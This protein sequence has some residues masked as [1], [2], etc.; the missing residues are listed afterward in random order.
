[1]PADNLEVAIRIRTQLQEALADF[2][3]L[4]QSL[5]KSGL[6]ADQA[7]GRLRRL[8]ATLDSVVRGTTTLGRHVRY[9]GIAL[10]GLSAGGFVRGVVRNTV[11]Q[12]QAIAQ[13]EARIRATGAAAGLTST[14]IQGMAAALQDVTTYGDE[15]ILEMQALLLSFRALDGTQFE[16]ITETALDLA[17]AL[18]QAP[19]EAAIQLAK[20]LED[21]VQGLTA[22][23]RS[24]TIFS[25]AQTEVIRSLAETGR[26]A[27]AQRL[28]LDE[29]ARQYGGA[30]R[31]ARDTLGGALAALDNA[32][33][34]L[35]EHTDRAGEMTAAVES[36]VAALKDEEATRN[37]RDLSVALLGMLR[38]MVEHADTVLAVAGA[39]AGAGLGAR[40][41]LKGLLVG[42]V[43]GGFAG[44]SLL[45]DSDEE[46]VAELRAEL[47]AAA[48]QLGSIAA[49]R[50]AAGTNRIAI[51]NLLDEEAAAT[52]RFTAALTELQAA[53][54]D[55]GDGSPYAAGTAG[56]HPAD[57]RGAPPP[58]AL[59]PPAG[60]GEGSEA[61]RWEAELRRA[62]AR[63]E[64][65]AHFRRQRDAEE[66]RLDAAARE[67]AA[68]REALAGARG[69]L[70][71]AEAD[72]AGPYARALAEVARWEKGVR[73]A[74]ARAAAGE[75]DY[76]RL[77]VAAAARRAGAAEAEAQRRLE[78]ARDWQSGVRRALADL[79]REWSDWG[80]AAEDATRTAVRGAEDAIVGFVS[81]GRV[82]IGDFARYVT[83]TLAR[84][85]V[86][87][88]FGLPLASLAADLFAP[89][90]TGGANGLPGYA[91]I[92][93]AGGIA[94]ALGGMRRHG[95]PDAAWWGAPRLHRGGLAAD[96]VPAI[97]RRGEGV[98]TPAQMAALGGM[99][100]PPSVVVEIR[101]QG[102]PQQVVGRQVRTDDLRR[103]IV[104]IVV[105]DIAHG[106]PIPRALGA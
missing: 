26:L 17:T 46:R 74:L 23:R 79:G 86:R 65:L 55:A 24:G 94:G 6:S 38:Y 12:E 73:A 39:V 2:R 42:A 21:P 16:R 104:G 10:S 80:R 90:G 97:L 11:R 41:G 102:T 20:A 69:A 13:V 82:D 96:E 15:A 59:P 50:Q 49:R 106:G 99:S 88:T 32:W 40:A 18:G 103:T 70:A 87:Q 56:P 54:R 25:A 8:G 83:E 71:A 75:E 105:D 44:A 67:R 58:A 61:D 81:R 77:A 30:A 76:T 33:G 3:R 68:R 64:G 53:L 84:V 5:R 95:V 34:D 63:A 1:M 7:R 98:F 85:F 66:R 47:D 89:P 100:A 36:L 19:R 92:A 37:V 52:R 27:E 57:R 93:H 9:L 62:R 78:T 101:N 28:I 14:E 51:R 60:E 91:D 48:D 72:L 22:L 35:L 31:A 4:D 43:V 45:G 29:L